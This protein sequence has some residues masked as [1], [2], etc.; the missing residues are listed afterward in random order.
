MEP[1]KLPKDVLELG[2][3]LVRELDL[4]DGVDTLGRWMAHHLAELI[5]K[6]ENGSTEDERLGAQTYAVETILKI[7]E[8]R[9]SL[10]GKA[11]PLK[12]Y[13]NVLIVL[14]RLRPDKNPFPRLAYYLGTERDK[15]ATML[16]DYFSRLIMALLLMSISADEWE[17]KVDTSIERSLSELEQHLLTALQQ[18][19]N[20]FNSTSNNST[21]ESPQDI[22]ESDVEADI[23]VDLDAVALRLIDDLME[24]LG[25]LRNTIKKE[26]SSRLL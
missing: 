25:D 26:Q 18:W 12:S 20:V 19:G 5:D 2:Q 21:N 3:H 7:W 24:S 16:F 8:H 23:K 6:A 9:S 22:K 11:Y 1:L 17:L 14:D 10:P 13:E 15:H 4:E